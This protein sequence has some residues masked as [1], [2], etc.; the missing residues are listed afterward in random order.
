M[1]PLLSDCD[2]RDEECAI[3]MNVCDSN[4][5]FRTVCAHE[6]CKTC[7]HEWHDRLRNKM[8]PFCRTYVVINER[9]PHVPHIHIA[10]DGPMNSQRN[11]ECLSQV[12]I[13]SFF[14]FI[15]PIFMLFAIFHENIV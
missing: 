13:R 11:V 8:C 4:D 6:Y 1:E 12:R 15:A 2:K 3:C 7:A 9:M 5:I 14:Y 10:I